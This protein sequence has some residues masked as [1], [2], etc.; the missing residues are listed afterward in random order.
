M[1][2]HAGPDI[3][4][5]GLVFCYDM[6]NTQKSWKGMPITNQKSTILSNQ[7]TPSQNYTLTT[8]SWINITD[9]LDITATKALS[10]LL[11]SGGQ[12]GKQ[13][14]W[15]NQGN[16]QGKTITW[17]WYVKSLSGDVA[18][19][20][21]IA[22]G[23]YGSGNTVTSYTATSQW[24]RVSVTRTI[25]TSNSITL[26]SAQD[27]VILDKTL[28]YTGFQLEE[29]SFATPFVNGTRSNTQAILDLTNNNT[30]TATS[31]TYNSDNIFSFGGQGETDGSP[32]GDYIT[33]DT[34]LTTTDPTIR[35]SGVTYDWWS[36]VS[37]AQPSGQCI[38]WGA[39]SINH[40]E[41]KGEG[42]ASPY[43]RTEAVQENG[44]SFGSGIISGGSLVGRWCHFAIVFANDEIGRPVRW[45]HNGELFYTGNMTGGVYPTSEYFYFSGLGRATGTVDYLY[46]NS[47]KGKISMLSIYHRPLSSAEIKQNFNANRMKYDI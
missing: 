19:T 13:W 26:G 6:N 5:N 17:S 14:Y 33:F 22:E 39:G 16:Y 36:Y 4:E 21:C 29:S 45:Y 34:N 7:I 9:I 44:Y 31:L 37:E 40:I 30:I 24:K 47:F 27:S 10:V 8:F 18:D 15:V 20:I 23:G 32:S 35:T 1:S 38:F 28:L 43:F 25:N 46:S 2:C 11:T 3:V 42:T 41:F 12:N